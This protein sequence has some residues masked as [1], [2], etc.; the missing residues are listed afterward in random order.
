M[1]HALSP[2]ARLA[3][4][5]GPRGAVCPH[6]PMADSPEGIGAEM[7]GRVV[8]AARTRVWGGQ[9]VGVAGEIGGIL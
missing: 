9:R 5:P 2:Q 8:V 3:P 6:R 1:R 7:K 4:R